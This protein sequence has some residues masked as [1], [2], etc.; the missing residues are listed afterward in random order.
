ML[1]TSG[2]RRTRQ[3]S[4]PLLSHPT[5]ESGEELS[6]ELQRK[7]EACP[8]PLFD[9]RHWKEKEKQKKKKPPQVSPSSLQGETWCRTET[10]R[11]RQGRCSTLCCNRA[12]TVTRAVRAAIAST[13]P[14]RCFL[15]PRWGAGG[16]DLSSGA[17]QIKP[18]AGPPPLT[19][20]AADNAASR[21]RVLLSQLQVF[22]A[23]A[24]CE[25]LIGHT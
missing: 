5:C 1:G 7:E 17:G 9:S 13:P 8:F 19:A 4:T 2:E 18:C 12:P 24:F 15:A 23:Q 11:G 20:E 6:V 16:C 21:W 10:W 25:C 14:A 3:E 22:I